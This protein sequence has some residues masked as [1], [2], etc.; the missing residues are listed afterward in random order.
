MLFRSEL[1]GYSTPVLIHDG[2][3]YGNIHYL[4]SI[5]GKVILAGKAEE[6]NWP[7]GEMDKAEEIEKFERALVTKLIRI[8]ETNLGRQPNWCRGLTKNGDSIFVTIDGRYDTD[9][10]FGV[11]EL[12]EDQVHSESRLRWS[13]IGDE[14][15]LR[16]VTG[17]DIL[18]F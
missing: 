5:D 4:T 11:L 18:S 17:F 7:G 8:D 15:E 14:K 16:Y 2:F 9:L 10:S 6:V 13:D 3:K 1:I 12:K